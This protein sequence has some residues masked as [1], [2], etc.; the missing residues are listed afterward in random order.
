MLKIV[1]KIFV[2]VVVCFAIF[3]RNDGACDVG[4]PKPF[5][6]KF[7]ESSFDGFV[8][9]TLAKVKKIQITKA[10]TSNEVEQT[11]QELKEFFSKPG[12]REKYDQLRQAHLKR[13]N[14]VNDLVQLEAKDPVLISELRG[15]MTGVYV[16]K[17]KTSLLKSSMPTFAEYAT[18]IRTAIDNNPDMLPNERE[19]LHR[20]VDEFFKGTGTK[21]SYERLGQN[22]QK[23]LQ[24]RKKMDGL[25]KSRTAVDR[26]SISIEYS[27][28][29]AKQV[30][31][32]HETLIA[33]SS[34]REEVE[35]FEKGCLFF[36]KWNKCAL[37]DL[38]Y[39]SMSGFITNAAILGLSDINT[40]IASI[41]WIMPQSMAAII[42]NG[43]EELV[44]YA[45][46]Q[47]KTEDEAMRFGLTAAWFMETMIQQDPLQQQKHN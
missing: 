37:A 27:N 17:L 10:V 7:F 34:I 26:T 22:Y 23:M 5:Y 47:A 36:A 35:A 42:E 21:E 4:N 31:A 12:M 32:D 30:L 24:A 39:A 45:A 43:T 15:R 19:Q 40:V 16:N 20:E 46:S 1:S 38:C 18:N 9:D 6:V 14:A 44:E 11:Q 3:S 13:R 25:Q 8:A 41:L 29:N 33:L 28:I 2:F